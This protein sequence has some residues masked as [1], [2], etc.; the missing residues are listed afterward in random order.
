MIG[1][2][3]AL[4]QAVAVSL[5]LHA[6]ML[7]VVGPRLGARA[8]ARPEPVTVLAARLDPVPERTAVKPAAPPEVLKN[9]LDPPQAK[10]L[11]DPIKPQPRRRVAEKD[12]PARTPKPKPDTPPPRPEPPEVS[13]RAEPPGR[14]LDLRMPETRRAERLTPEDL[15]ETLGRLSEELLYPADALR[16]GLEGEV[17]ILVEL[18]EDGR[19]LDASIASGSGHQSLDDAAVRAVKRLG[20]LGPASAHKTILLPVRFRIL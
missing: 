7:F 3:S 6:L 19:I 13:A 16:R 12:Q 2:R 15:R 11:P 10:P 1:S 9:T 18:G 4:P 8:P 14:G 5:M 17:T 20:T